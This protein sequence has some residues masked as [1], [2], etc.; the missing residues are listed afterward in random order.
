MICVEN[1]LASPLQR[2]DS[3]LRKYDFRGSATPQNKRRS[4]KTK[5]HR[6]E[7]FKGGG[8]SF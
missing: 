4:K 3:V 7:F 1:K 2:K 8:V 5:G 6:K